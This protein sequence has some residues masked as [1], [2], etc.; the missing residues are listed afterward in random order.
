MCMW[1]QR[2]SPWSAQSKKV[3]HVTV[4]EDSEDDTDY[5]TDDDTRDDTRDQ[6]V[7]KTAPYVTPSLCLDYMIICD[8]CAY[9]LAQLPMIYQGLPVILYVCPV[10]QQAHQTEE[11]VIQGQRP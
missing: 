1:L 10:S 3:K 7:R 5:V 6:S 11:V 2:R 9:Y 4:E 8:Y